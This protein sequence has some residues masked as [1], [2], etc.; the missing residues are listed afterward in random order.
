MISFLES[1]G[2]PLPIETLLV[3]GGITYARLATDISGYYISYNSTADTFVHLPGLDR[4]N[5]VIRPN[6][7][8][9][10]IYA[11]VEMYYRNV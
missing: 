8:M 9:A 10:V 11:S 2:S 1:H 4:C 3:Q 5:V 6:Y 7:R